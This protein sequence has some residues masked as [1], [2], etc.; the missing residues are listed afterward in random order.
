MVA[1]QLHYRRMIK[2]LSLLAYFIL[3]SLSV[4]AQNDSLILN[5]GDKMIGEIKS[6]EKGVLT[7]ETDYSDKDFLIEWDKIKEIYSENKFL[8]S[9]NTGKRITASIETKTPGKI[10]LNGIEGGELIIKIMGDTIE[11]NQQDIVYINSLDDSFLSRLSASI[12]VGYSLAKANN[13]QQFN[14]NTRLGYLADLW[15]LSF[16]YNSLFTS[17]D[18]ID[19]IERNEGGLSFR[20]FLPKDYYFNIASNFLSN[21]EQAIELRSSFSG[22]IGKYIIHTNSAYI[23]FGIGALSNIEKF[24]NDTP[25]RE[26]WEAYLGFEANLFDIGDFSFFSTVTAFPSITEKGRFRTDLS[27]DAEYDDFIFDDFYIRAGINLNYDNQPAIAGN[28][29]DYVFTTGF[30]WSW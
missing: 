30:G 9:L 7:V 21:T 17:Q 26:S 25:D 13:Q 12:D 23:G 2:Y 27:V 24:S 29:T 28:E 20:Y 10:I 18:S 14:A 15:S 19:N 4:L 5:N 3:L 16:F 1:E 6:M 8:I 22:G 11:V